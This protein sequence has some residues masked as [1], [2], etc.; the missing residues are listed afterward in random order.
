MPLRPGRATRTHEHQELW[1]PSR[2][3]GTSMEGTALNAKGGER[4]VERLRRNLLRT[5]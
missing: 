3:P 1:Q 2:A 4:L 5:R